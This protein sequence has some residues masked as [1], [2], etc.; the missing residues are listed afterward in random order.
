VATATHINGHRAL[1]W[2]AVLIVAA[3]WA[4]PAQAT[5]IWGSSA[6]GE[7][8][9][10]RDSAVSPS[11][12]IHGSNAWGN[13]GFGVSWDITHNSDAGTWT[14]EYLFTASDKSISHAI[15]EVTLDEFAFSLFDGSSGF[16]MPE[17]YSDSGSNPLMPNPLFGVKYDLIDSDDA[18]E[19]PLTIVTDR[20]PVYGVFYAKGGKS[21]GPDGGEWM[22]AWS[23]GLNHSNYQ[24]NTSLSVT[25][26]IV[27][28]N[29]STPEEP[30]TFAT[31]PEP[32]T[33]VLGLLG[34]LALLG[35]VRRRR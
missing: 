35:P 33:A 5:P 14:Y 11:G 9:G 15:L 22:V 25:D 23:T 20:A 12:G 2:S 16:T 13:G 29:G 7:L 30:G 4:A 34:A 24:T 6:V 19:L 8:T 1:A 31:N 17:T 32:G 10:S 18:N 21:R 26:F 3:V 27:R 28:P